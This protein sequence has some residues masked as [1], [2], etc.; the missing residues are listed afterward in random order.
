MKCLLV[1]SAHFSPEVLLLQVCVQV[2]F[3]S[4]IHVVTC[5]LFQ[6]ALKFSLNG[7]FG[8]QKYLLYY[9]WSQIIF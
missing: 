3:T 6:F 1:F 2:L 8:K 7:M 5:V 4:D 9:Q